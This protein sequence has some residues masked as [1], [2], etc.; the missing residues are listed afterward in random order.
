MYR[1][2]QRVEPADA[3]QLPAE[4]DLLGRYAEAI[5]APGGRAI[6]A[7]RRPARL[8]RLDANVGN[9]LYRQDRFEEAL[10]LYQRAYD[11]SLKS[12]SRRISPSR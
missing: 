1:L 10:E 7:A 12:A 11:A 8:A 6:S 5:D 4:P 9:I 3:Q 2:G